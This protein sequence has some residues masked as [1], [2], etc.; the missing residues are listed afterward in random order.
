MRGEEVFFCPFGTLLK[1]GIRNSQN[2]KRDNQI[3]DC[4]FFRVDIL[5]PTE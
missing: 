4:P 2:N 3:D 1:L 5:Y